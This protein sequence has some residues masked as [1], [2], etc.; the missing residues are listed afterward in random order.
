MKM[1]ISTFTSKD[2]IF[3]RVSKIGNDIKID[4]NHGETSSKPSSP[5]ED[6]H[7]IAMTGDDLQMGL[8]DPK[9][10]GLGSETEVEAGYHYG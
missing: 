4:R 6:L 3:C 5:V 2:F 9:P 1:G 8:R 7:G 10:D